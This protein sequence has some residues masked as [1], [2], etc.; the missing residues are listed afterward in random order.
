MTA[1]ATMMTANIQKKA[2]A[3]FMPEPPGAR[4]ADSLSP[5]AG[6]GLG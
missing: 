5:L 4:R 6:R 1:A 2:A 3:M